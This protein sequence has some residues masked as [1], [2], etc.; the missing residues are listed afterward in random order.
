MPTRADYES[1]A[2]LF[3]NQARSYRDIAA[4]TPR[5]TA[6]SFCNEGPATATI[7]AAV[8]RVLGHV[9]AAADELDRAAAECDRRAEVCAQFRRAVDRYWSLPYEVRELTPYPARPASWA[10]T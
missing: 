2:S 6:A 10:D 1:T 9:R 3:R 7:D 4:F 8:L 5:G